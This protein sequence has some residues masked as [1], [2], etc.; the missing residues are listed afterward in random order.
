MTGWNRP[1][2]GFSSDT[3]FLVDAD[4]D[5]ADGIRNQRDLVLRTAPRGSGTFA[6]YDLSAQCRAQRAAPAAGVPVADPVLEEPAG[7][8]GRPFLLMRRVEGHVVGERHPAD[9]WLVSLDD[10]P[11]GAGWPGTAST[12]WP[13]STA[14]VPPARTRSPTATTAP[15]ST[16]GSAYLDWSSG[17]APVPTLVDALGLVPSPPARRGA[18][19]RSCCGGTPAS[20]TWWSATTSPCGPCSTGT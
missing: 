14:P 12:Y 1:P 10:G 5:E 19:C 4:V 18:P 20:R 6:D 7:W 11:P 16:T 3:V 2:A 8:I 13:G 9:P 17:G 15:N